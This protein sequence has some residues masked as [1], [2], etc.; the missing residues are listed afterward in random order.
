MICMIRPT[1]LVHRTFAQSYIE[2][3]QQGLQCSE[4]VFHKTNGDSSV[5]FHWCATVPSK[6][7]QT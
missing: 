7:A 4:S 1:L 6:F 3:L 5:H 2:H